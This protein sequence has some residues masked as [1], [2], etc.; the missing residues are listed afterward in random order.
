[1]TLPTI[2]MPIY[3]M[4]IPSSGE[5]IKVRPFTVK[6]EKLLLMAAES[7]NIKDVTNTVKQVINNCIISGKFDVENVPFF[8][9]DYAFIYLRAKSIGEKQEIQLNCRNKPDEVNECGATIPA[10][11]DMNDVEVVKNPDLD[12]DIK[13]DKGKGVIMKYPPYSAIKSIEEEKQ[14]IDK[15][16]MMIIHC[17]DKIYDKDNVYPAKDHSIADLKAF[18]EQ[19]SESNFKKLEAWTKDFPTF[20]AVI[21]AKCPK[22]GFEHHVRYSDFEDFFT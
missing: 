4:K 9:I 10:F 21:D 13:L 8:D 14:P 5:T 11:V 17:I 12:F 19:L 3:E 20:L 22:C 15:T 1:M 16:I 2:D 7:G 6:E 18:I